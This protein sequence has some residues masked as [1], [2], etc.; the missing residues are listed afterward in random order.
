[1]GQ[2]KPADTRLHG[3]PGRLDGG[4]VRAGDGLRLQLVQV[5]RLVDEEI[6]AAGETGESGAG[7]RVAAEDHRTTRLGGAD[8][9]LLADGPPPD[10]D[11][12]LIKQAAQERPRRDAGRGRALQVDAAPPLV[13]LDPKREAHAHVLDPRGDHAEPFGLHGRPVVELLDVDAVIDAAREPRQHLEKLPRA[14]GAVDPHRILAAEE[15][16][17]AEVARQAQDV[18]Q[19][20]VRE[21][22]AL[23][24]EAGAA[25][26]ELPLGPFSAVEEDRFP[27]HA[28]GVRG[29]VPRRRG[30]GAAGQA[31]LGGGAVRSESPESNSGAAR[32]SGP[33]PPGPPGPPRTP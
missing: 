22:N 15:S 33:S 28:D 6:G 24:A 10:L 29:D 12:A 23:D 13:L 3:R 32:R 26:L 5:R 30:I 1:M 17:R 2:R 20:E 9:V 19:V 8:H 14:E 21:E 4:R 31:R 11:A 16:Q 25:P 18:V 27:L 7:P